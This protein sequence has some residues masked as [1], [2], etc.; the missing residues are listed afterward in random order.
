MTARLH[1]LSLQHVQTISTKF[2]DNQQFNATAYQQ[3]TSTKRQK[4]MP[5]SI[6]IT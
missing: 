3:I 4:E 6:M 2:L 5:K 1:H